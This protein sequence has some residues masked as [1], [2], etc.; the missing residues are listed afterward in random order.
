MIFIFGLN[1]LKALDKYDQ[2]TYNNID[3]K[4]KTAQIELRPKS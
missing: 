4:S 2:L 1:K 3:T